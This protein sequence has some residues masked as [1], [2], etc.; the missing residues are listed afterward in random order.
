MLDV[1]YRMH[2]L[3]RH[4][5]SLHFYSDKLKDGPNTSSPDYTQAF[6]KHFGPYCFFDLTSTESSVKSS[7]ANHKEAKFVLELYQTL[8]KLHPDAEVIFFI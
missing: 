6:H 4:F 7:M 2:P 1:Q 8:S 3:I 5:P